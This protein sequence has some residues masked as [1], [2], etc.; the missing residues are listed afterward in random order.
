MLYFLS[1]FWYASLTK[2][3][4]T[5][6]SNL[7]LC[8]GSNTFFGFW[9]IRNPTLSTCS[10]KNSTSSLTYLD[11]GM[12]TPLTLVKLNMW[13][14]SATKPSACPSCSPKYLLKWS[15]HIRLTILLESNSEGT[16]SPTI[17]S[18]ILGHLAPA[19]FVIL[20]QVCIYLVSTCGP[21]STLL[22][23]VRVNPL[24]FHN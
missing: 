15:Y 22:N 1:N 24:P 7:V 14:A 19:C 17:L 11:N 4:P 10:P 23:Q 16:D 18:L 21:V 13:W 2:F 8:S 12:A 3:H 9:V 6:L 5:I 20:N